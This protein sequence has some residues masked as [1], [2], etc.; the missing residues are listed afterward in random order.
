MNTNTRLVELTFGR[1]STIF[2]K[3]TLQK[4]RLGGGDILRVILQKL[5]ENPFGLGPGRT[6]AITEGMAQMID[7]DP[8]YNLDYSWHYDNLWVT[9]VIEFGFLGLFYAGLILSSPVY[10]A[11]MT[12]GVYRRGKKQHLKTMIICTLTV[13]LIVLANW[14]G[15]GIPYNPVSFMFWFWVAI[16]LQTYRKSR[17]EDNL[18]IPSEFEK[19]M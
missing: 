14:G 2:E 3:E 11:A 12:M 13:S 1:F 4:S 5:D 19:S 18:G 7:R 10:L 15:V 9:I 8:I 6:H 17:A 16:G